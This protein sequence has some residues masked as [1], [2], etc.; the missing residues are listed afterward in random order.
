MGI[1][2]VMVG[3]GPRSATPDLAKIYNPGAQRIHV[4]RNPIIVIPGI[5]GSKLVD[6]QG[7]AVWGVFG[8]GGVNHRKGDGM[9]S[10]SLPMSASGWPKD[11]VRADGALEELHVSLGFNFHFKAY[12]RMLAAFGAGGYIDPAHVETGGVDYGDEHFTCF[13]FAYDWRRSNAE[14]AVRLDQ[15]IEEKAR[16]VEKERKRR[17]GTTGRVKFDVIAHSMGGLVARYHLMYGGRRLNADGQM[18]VTWAGARRVEKLIMV[19]TPNGGSAYAYKNL[20]EGLKLSSLLPTIQPAVIGT[21]PSAYEL[22]PPEGDGALIDEH[23]EPINYYNVDEWE[24]RGWGLMNPDQDKVLAELMPDEGDPGARRNR[25]RSHLKKVLTNARAFHRA[26]NRPAALPL[27]VEVHAFVGDA[28][29]TAS[30]LQVQG[31][32]ELSLIDWIPGDGTVT[33]KSVMRDLRTP[34]E[35]GS[36]VKGPIKWTGAHFVFSDHVGMTSDPAFVD[37]VL[38]LLLE[39]P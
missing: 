31:D 25:A 1:C 24:R 32:G 17:Y 6:S 3:C 7:N 39:R 21:M 13:Q 20:N 29:S 27:G 33:R 35:A 16:Y 10:M 28:V 14:N 30:R 18:P 5:M 19:G 2:L 8:P 9:R 11:D 22:L 15:F 26:I 34:E 12:S 36:P 37:N 23:S 38:Y 4:D